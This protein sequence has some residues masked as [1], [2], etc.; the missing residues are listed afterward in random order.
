[1][2]PLFISIGNIPGHICMAATSH[3]W[4]CVVFMPIPKFDVP[5]TCQTIL[6]H[7]LWHKCINIATDSLKRTMVNGR[8]MVDPHGHQHNCFTPLAAWTAD[9]PEQL[10]ITCVAKNAS[11]VTEATHKQF[12]DANRHLSQTGELTLERINNIAQVV[13][14]WNLIRFQ[15][16]AK[17]IQL[18]GTHL[19]CWRNWLYTEPSIFLVPKVLHYC[20]K[21]FSIMSSSG[22]RKWLA[23]NST[24]DPSVITNTL[25]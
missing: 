6:Q 12:G 21:S 15:K 10:T 18:S 22:A 4:R 16:Q 23:R 19:P 20:H 1:M 13:N 24:C 3:A 8:I 2:H 11:P 5:S 25:W 9:L 7:R 14:P 17:A